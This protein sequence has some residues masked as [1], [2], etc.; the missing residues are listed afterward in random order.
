MSRLLGSTALFAT[1]M[2]ASVPQGL[3]QTAS[4]TAQPVTVA[5]GDLRTALDQVADLFGLQLVVQGDLSGIE[6]GAL[7]ADMSAREALKSLLSGSGYGFEFVSDD[8]VIIKPVTTTTGDARGQVILPEV[9]VTA[10]RSRRSIATMSPSVVVIGPDQIEAQSAKSSDITNVI[11]NNVPGFMFDDQSLISSTET[12]RGRD[13]QVLVDGVARNTPLRNSSR[14]LSMIDIQQVESIEV[15]P[16]SNAM[17]GDGATGATINII[18]KTGEVGKNVFVV[19]GHVKSYT[20][21]IGESF[22]PSLTLSGSGGFGAV[23]LAASI[24]GSKTGNAYDGYG[25][26]VPS[27]AMLGQGGFDNAEDLNVFGK[28][29]VTL[30]E[31][32]RLFLS[33][34][35]VRFR[36]DIEYFS[37]LSTDPV[38]VNYDAPYTG[39]PLEEESQY[40]TGGYEFDFGKVGTG[41]IKLF[42]NDS[43]KQAARAEYHAT[44]NPALVSLASN[45]AI[46]DPL[47]QSVIDAVK[48]GVKL[49]TDTSLDAAYEG[50][51]LTWGGDLTFDDVKYRTVSNRDI[52][53]PME[54]DG[55]AIFAQLSAPVTEYVDLSGGVRY[56]KYDLTVKD[57][58]RPSYMRYNGGTPQ[59]ILLPAAFTGG[60]TTYDAV[61]YNAS[62]V[63]HWTERF[64]TSLSY[65]EGFSVPDVGAYTRRAGQ[66]G[67]SVPLNFSD[68]DVEASKVKTYEL[69][70]RYD[71]TDFRTTGAVYMS[72]NDRG[73]NYD[74]ATNKL[75]QEKERI[76][77]A[78][79]TGEYDISDDTYV[80]ALASYVEG[81]YDTNEDGDLDSWLPNN[82][83]PS[84]FRF[85]GYVDSY[86]WGD[87]NM[88]FDGTYTAGRYK[89]E[90]K[91]IKPSLVFNLSGNYPL[92]G[93]TARFGI[94]NILDSSYENPAATALRGYSVAGHGRTVTIGYRREF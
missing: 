2:I 23:D 8:S 9:V 16:G 3:A 18:T 88:R 43:Y 21:D 77:G 58:T 54:Q 69:A 73:D 78:E 1:L 26:Q 81:R 87:L 82:R 76:I 84:P 74:S 63:V 27:D 91:K 57:F 61:T 10:T 80:G 28:A 90:D 32:H 65:S 33:S 60:K 40:F 75:S 22:S 51:T 29:G 31:G 53:A 71:G 66:T 72:T 64:D 12:F 11:R 15:I 93:G 56:E 92:L 86:V 49:S 19:D 68:I 83:I 70:A 41:D 59:Q 37:D 52:G 46:E 55:K 36:Q 34:E 20:D 79:L 47:G 62:A 50:L 17:N 39:Q 35:V 67:T 6:S 94:E 48:Y 13:V 4:D 14:I 45:G 44:Y 7:T 85:T 5:A 30:A 42:Y 89:I 24:T 38:S 25:N